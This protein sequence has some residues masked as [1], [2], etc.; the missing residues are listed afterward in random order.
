M[1]P[2]HM[3]AEQTLNRVS[4]LGAVLALILTIAV[5]A[6]QVIPMS[7]TLG[8]VLFATGLLC[9]SVR[10]WGTISSLACA[11]GLLAM[12]VAGVPGLADWLPS[13]FRL[14]SWLGSLAAAMA[15][16][17]LMSLRLRRRMWFN[18]SVWLGA[19][20]VTVAVLSLLSG[21]MGYASMRANIGAVLALLVG[22][23]LMVARMG[24]GFLQLIER[25]SPAGYIGRWML[26]I[27]ILVPALLHIAQ[28]KYQPPA[29]ARALLPLV[30]SSFAYTM[31][32]LGVLMFSLRRLDILELSRAE[33]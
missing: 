4:T 17:G 2:Y 20:V 30:L 15:G 1:A 24:Q 12:S 29:N 18:A 3:R 5:G 33:A 9:W 8:I 19:G 6:F 10:G 7:V 11:I 21:A 16:L 22:I 25:R 14:Q 32:L 13:W 27:V 31:A 28:L 26:V 23:S